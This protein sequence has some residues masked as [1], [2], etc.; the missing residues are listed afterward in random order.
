MDLLMPEV[1]VAASQQIALGLVDLV[2]VDAPRAC[3]GVALAPADG[4]DFEI[5]LSG[6]RAARSG[7]AQGKV[8][9]AAE[10]C[11]ANAVA[12]SGSCRHSP[13]CW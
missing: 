2:R 1:D 6:A 8:G 3:G 10:M 13:W 9:L 11:G 7:T 4:N 12:T 5:L